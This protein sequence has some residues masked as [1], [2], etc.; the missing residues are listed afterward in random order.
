MHLGRFLVSTVPFLLPFVH[1]TGIGQVNGANEALAEEADSY[2]GNVNSLNVANV[3]IKGP[4]I[5]NDLDTLIGAVES[6]TQNAQGIAATSD[7]GTEETLLNSWAAASNAIAGYMEDLAKKANLLIL[8]KQKFSNALGQLLSDYNAYVAVI[9]GLGAGTPY[10]N[11][12]DRD[13]YNAAEKIAVAQDAF[14]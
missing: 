2:D 1:A 8:Q 13:G 11:S 5:F 10:K 14:E 4:G 6:S 9:E 12:V 7:P 3:V